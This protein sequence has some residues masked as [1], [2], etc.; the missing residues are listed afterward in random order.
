MSMY[1][2]MSKSRQAGKGRSE[3]GSFK[4]PDSGGVDDSVLWWYENFINEQI[5]D[6]EDPED[7]SLGLKEHLV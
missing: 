2:T 7:M 6:T 5:E 4:N 3:K 1:N